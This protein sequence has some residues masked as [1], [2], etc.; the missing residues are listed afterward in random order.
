MLFPMLRNY[1]KKETLRGAWQAQ[2]VEPVA[3][4]LGDPEVEPHAG[5]RVY[6]KKKSLEKSF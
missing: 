2:E 3:L 4:D 1:S 6:L 5:G